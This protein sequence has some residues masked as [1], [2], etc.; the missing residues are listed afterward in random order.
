MRTSTNVRMAITITDGRATT[1]LP[2]GDTVMAVLRT[3]L[4]SRGAH[5]LFLGVAGDRLAPPTGERGPRRVANL[6]NNATN[7]VATNR[8]RG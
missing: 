8:P 3:P 4:I 5:A 7:Y 2:S 6:I 1:C